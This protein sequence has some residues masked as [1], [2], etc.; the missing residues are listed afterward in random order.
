MSFFGND[1][2]WSLVNALS[3]ANSQGRNTSGVTN[4][5]Q[6]M[7]FRD[8]YLQQLYAMMGRPYY[9]PGA[10]MTPISQ[11]YLNS[12]F[13]RANLPTSMSQWDEADQAY[14]T[15]LE[16]GPYQFNAHLLRD[17]NIDA[18]MNPYQQKVMEEQMKEMNR[19]RQIALKE[20]SQD[21][22]KA[23]AFGGTRFAIAQGETNRGYA[24]SMSRASAD[25]L[26]KGYNDAMGYM[27]QD[28]DR[29]TQ[30]DVNN[31]GERNSYANRAVSVGNALFNS[32]STRLNAEREN[33]NALTEMEMIRQRRTDELQADYA[34]RM[35]EGYNIYP[36]EKMKAISSMFSSLPRNTTQQAYGVDPNDLAGLLGEM[37][38]GPNSGFRPNDPKNPAK[39][40]DPAKPGTQAQQPTNNKPITSNEA[41]ELRRLQ[42]LKARGMPLNTFQRNRLTELEGRQRNA[43]TAA[44]TNPNGMGWL[45][46]TGGNTQYRGEPITNNNA[47]ELRSRLA[48]LDGKMRDGTLSAEEQKEQQSLR[49]ALTAKGAQEKEKLAQMNPRERAKFERMQR[50]MAEQ[51]YRNINRL[52][53]KITAI[54]ANLPNLTKA[55]RIESAQQQ[56]IKEREKLQKLLAEYQQISASMMSDD[57]TNPFDDEMLNQLTSDKAYQEGL[58]RSGLSAKTDFSEGLL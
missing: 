55:S 41:A 48:E 32:G 11:D 9:D 1:D 30:A 34:K 50:Q 22:T 16:G 23:K 44:G 8:A 3:A 42:E 54:E 57:P 51:L 17:Q 47:Q 38:D 24:D 10:S 56:L 5:A 29:L 12:M 14:R 21:S 18:Y 33:A 36:V 53:E 7:Q 37:G 6:T 27:G 31:A 40:N 2:P 25:L 28:V 58:K 39:P 45:L 20:L 26:Y 43:S 15:A 4:D 49:A 13:Q 52:Y 19:Q 46:S 35:N